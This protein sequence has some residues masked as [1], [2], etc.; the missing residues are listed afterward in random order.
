MSN[1]QWFY[2]DAQQQQQGPVAFEQIQQLAASGQIQ[3]TTLIWNESMP[4]WAAASQVQGVF[5][6]GAPPV[7]AAAPGNPYAAPGS[8]NPLGAPTVG[9]SYPI[10]VVK[11]VSYPLFLTTFIAGIVLYFVA[12]G[13]IFS[14]VA[15]TA[16]EMEYPD[17]TASPLETM[18]DVEN[19]D[20]QR[21]AAAQQR[22][23]QQAEIVMEEFPIAA[24]GFGMVGMILLLVAAILGFICIYR[25]WCCL[26]PGGARTTP[27]KAVGFLFIPIFQLYW[28]FV[29]YHGWSQDWTRIQA[30]HGNLAGMPRVSPP[31]FL[32]TLI[33]GFCIIIPILNLIAILAYP[34]LYLIMMAQMHKVVNA[35]SA[36]SQP[37]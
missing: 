27:G 17:E 14:S 34:I 18:G 36:A 22:A 5:N 8:G 16:S 33:T 26:Q 30:S 32:A 12:V 19:L 37:R 6:A 31:L 10:P 3:A 2:A 29:A 20:A 1:V 21:E 7:T 23:E 11:K 9:G 13:I 24:I 4:S 15:K 35:M 28:I 25:A